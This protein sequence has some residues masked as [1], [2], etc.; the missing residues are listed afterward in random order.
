MAHKVAVKLFNS[1]ESVHLLNTGAIPLIGLYKSVE[2]SIISEE[3]EN[4]TEE[5]FNEAEALSTFELLKTFIKSG[6]RKSI[7]SFKLHLQEHKYKDKIVNFQDPSNGETLLHIGAYEA[8][9]EIIQYL[10]VS[11]ADPYTKDEK[12]R[13][14][15]HS[16]VIGSKTRIQ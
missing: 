14:C 9:D 5:E 12:G 15:L 3:D 4:D 6:T 1:P 11:N 13:S 8:N 10:L 7:E 2:T 16:V